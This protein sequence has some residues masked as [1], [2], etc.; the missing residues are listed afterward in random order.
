MVDVI[1][2]SSLT[3]PYR[4]LRFNKEIYGNNATQSNPNHFLDN[5]ELP[6][7]PSYRAFNGAAIFCPDRFFARRE[8]YKSI[9]VV[10][11]RIYISFLAT[12]NS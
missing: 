9:A 2:V 8:V 7:S 1:K 5:K 11:Y 4:Q 6:R 10:L 3:V 12:V